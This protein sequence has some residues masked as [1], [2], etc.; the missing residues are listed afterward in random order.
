V[1]TLVPSGMSTVIGFV[2]KCSLVSSQLIIYATTDM[3]LMIKHQG[4]SDV[5][6]HKECVPIMH[7][8]QTGAHFPLFMSRLHIQ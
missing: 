2:T 7:I 3:P 8:L 5:Q 4:Q 1:S 6:N